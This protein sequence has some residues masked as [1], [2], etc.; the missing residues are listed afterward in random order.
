[1]RGSRTR[2]ISLAVFAVLA[3]SATPAFAVRY[4]ALPNA[5]PDRSSYA[6]RALIEQGEPYLRLRWKS[7]DWR[8]YEVLLAAPMVIPRG[9][10]DI[11]LEQLGSDQVL[12]D[13]KRPGDALVRVRWTPYWFAAGGCVERAGGWTRVTAERTG[14]M[15]LSTRFAPERVVE[16]G[17]RCDDG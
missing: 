4:V 12:L 10:A 17:R 15:R 8:V 9:R 1:M 6:E 11:E 14:F 13:V 7:E 2:L 5:K 16:H 3:T